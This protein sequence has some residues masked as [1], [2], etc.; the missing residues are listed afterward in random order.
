MD[1]DSLCVICGHADENLIHLFFECNVTMQFW[2]ELYSHV[3]THVNMLYCFSLK[4]VICYYK[5]K[6]NKCL[7][8]L[9]NF[10]ILLGKYFIHKQ[11]FSASKPTFP[12][13]LTE[14]NLLY[15]S[16]A[17]VKNKKNTQFF[18]Y[19]EKIFDIPSGN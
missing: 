18:D 3:F 10:F 6:K 7:Q 16:L 17:L 4:D 11:K 9:V 1:V 13:F 5:N 15:K 19:Y 8:Y 2:S 14:F 12:H